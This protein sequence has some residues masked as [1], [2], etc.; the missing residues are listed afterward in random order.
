MISPTEKFMTTANTPTPKGDAEPESVNGEVRAIGLTPAERS[1]RTAILQGPVGKLTG[2]QWIERRHK[3]PKHHE[4]QK[5]NLLEAYM[6]SPTQEL[7]TQLTQ[8][9]FD[10]IDKALFRLHALERK[11]GTF[12]P[13]TK[14]GE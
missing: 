7:A 13:D 5:W 11:A 9:G 12:A 4:Q 1:E 8:L 2:K 6:L 14:G 10:E 3:L